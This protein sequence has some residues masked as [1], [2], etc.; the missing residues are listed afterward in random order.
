M[1]IKEA[2]NKI[3]Y[4]HRDTLDDF[5]LVIVDRTCNSGYK[6]IGFK[7]I[8]HI[9]NYY[10]YIGKD[11]EPTT[12]IPIHRVVRIEKKNGEIVWNRDMGSQ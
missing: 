8:K 5:M 10:V 9:D 2:V 7:Q 12:S 1:R 6:Y 4:K 11:N 3:L